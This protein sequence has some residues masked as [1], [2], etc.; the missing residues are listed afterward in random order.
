MEGW[1]ERKKKVVFWESGRVNVVWEYSTGDEGYLALIF[2]VLM[3][4][5]NV[6]E[7]FFLGL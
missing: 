4:F 6:G 3:K 1:K 5:V 2:T 7:C